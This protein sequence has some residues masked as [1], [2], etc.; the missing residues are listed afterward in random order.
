MHN[1]LIDLIKNVIRTI[2]LFGAIYSGA[3]AA[4]SDNDNFMESLICVIA[5]SGFVI[6]TDKN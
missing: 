5:C 6:T 3:I 1:F 2:L 4:N